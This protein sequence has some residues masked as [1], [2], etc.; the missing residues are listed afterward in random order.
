MRR[1]LSLVLI[2]PLG[3]LACSDN[4]D[5]LDGLTAV[6]ATDSAAATDAATTD[7]ATTDAGTTDAAT[8]DS[9]PPATS[10]SDPP[11]PTG[12]PVTSTSTSTTSP[13]DPTVDPSGE[14]GTST[15]GDPDDPYE[16][17]RQLCV[18][19]INMYRATLGLPPYARWTDAESCADAEALA[20]G[21]SNTPHGTFGMCGEWA[22]NECPGWP[23][24]PEQSLPG[25]L[26]QMW[27]EG[28]GEDFNLHGHYI[29]MSS[30]Q[31]TR[32][33]CGFADVGG[34]MWMVQNFQ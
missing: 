11:D 6:P 17:A 9:D 15:T 14:P 8:T 26:A 2:A 3:L 27:A 7:A 21:Q 12:G 5:P 30:E 4:K 22:Q 29:N 34:K 20:D 19:T 31:Y 18:D 13:P 33:A 10:T 24:P 25:C 1:T 32:V 23:S 16:Q 28:P